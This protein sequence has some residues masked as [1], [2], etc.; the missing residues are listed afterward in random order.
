V[1][2]ILALLA[3]QWLVEGLVEG[4]VE[5]EVMLGVAENRIRQRH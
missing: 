2:I 4:L 5:A 1:T 3:R